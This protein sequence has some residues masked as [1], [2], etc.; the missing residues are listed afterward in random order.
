MEATQSEFVLIAWFFR[1]AG[2][3][4]L[5]ILGLGLLLSLWGLVNLVS[6]R[7][8][9]EIIPQ[10]YVSFLPLLISLGAMVI[11]ARDFVSMVRGDVAATTGEFVQTCSFGLVC[12][13]LGSACTLVPALLGLTHLALL[14]RRV[15]E[16]RSN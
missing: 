10:I 14:L 12:G 4:G 15:Q 16:N 13:I 8:S 6:A 5:V 7:S 1:S 3:C 11:V 9:S 2:S